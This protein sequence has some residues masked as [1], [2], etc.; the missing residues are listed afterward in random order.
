[1]TSF[2]DETMTIMRKCLVAPMKI[3]PVTGSGFWDG[4][5][6][7]E[8]DKVLEH[9]HRKHHNLWLPLFLPRPPA[10]V[11]SLVGLYLSTSDITVRTIHQWH[12][13]NQSAKRRAID[14]ARIDL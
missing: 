3:E 2:V 14:R 12:A 6:S 7:D 9:H 1:M 8:Y 13:A 4:S 10:I 11:F 5:Y